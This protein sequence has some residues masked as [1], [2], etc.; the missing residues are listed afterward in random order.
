V[1]GGAIVPIDDPVLA[2]V[3]N[4]AVLA[5]PFP[6]VLAA[7]ALLVLSLVARRTA[8]GLFVEAT[9]GNAPASRVAGVDVRAVMLLVFALSGLLSGV[10]GLVV[11]ADIRAADS[12]NAGLYLELDAIL[13]VVVG[14]TALGGGRFSLSG[15]FV[16]ALAL[17]ALTTTILSRGVAVEWT[18]VVKAV[19]VLSLALLRSERVRDAMAARRRTA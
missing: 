8:T 3:G 13:A 16:G 17:Q 9:G 10:A 5:L 6:V 18:L 1:T 15:A 4:G 12:N 19:V 2:F 11:A 7:A 14:G